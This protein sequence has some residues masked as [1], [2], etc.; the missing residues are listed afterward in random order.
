MKKIVYI[1]CTAVLLTACS[2][3]E[4]KKQVPPIRVSVLE[5]DTSATV[6]THTYVG[7]TQEATSLP[8]SF[9]MG[10]KITEVRVK[11]GDKVTAGQVLLRTDNT[12]AQNS[13]RSAK[14]QLRYAEEGY[15][16]TKQLY[17]QGGV[18]EMKYIEVTS[19]Y[20]TAQSLVSLAQKE[21]DNCTLKA[22]QDGIVSRCEVHVGQNLLPEQ[23]ALTLL[24]VNG[25]LVTFSV[26][27]N[28]I[29]QVHI[30]DS[31]IVSLPALGN[32][33]CMAVV[34]ERSLTGS[35]YAHSYDIKMRIIDRPEHIMPGMV[36]K[37]TLASQTQQ[38]YRIPSSCVRQL[39]QGQSVWVM[40]NGEAHRRQVQVSQY[41]SG[42]VLVTDG[43]NK[44]DAVIAGGY[45][46]LY[47]GA[48]IIR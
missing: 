17:E 36:C 43:L 9:I 26:P 16:R 14:A 2:Q 29:A 12:Q 47:E 21:V 42:G 25:L 28:D 35:R 45:Q 30:G 15:N 23:T 8:L 11:N 37:V 20:R 32:T 48:K 3:Q 13:L 7:E 41:L 18:A 27:E 4:E 6:S 19:Q 33:I 10:G 46:K 1:L 44:G 22:P 40:E 38:G 24:D 5:M 31:A 34:T 39:P